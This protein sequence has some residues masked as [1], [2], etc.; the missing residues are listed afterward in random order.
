MFRLTRKVQHVRAEGRDRVFPEPTSMLARYLRVM[1]ELA[2]DPDFRRQ[3][4][5]TLPAG[6]ELLDA[7]VPMIGRAA[8]SRSAGELS[9]RR[10][11]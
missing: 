6:D 1:L 5:A 7:H 2:A 9:V 10:R 4:A 3:I 8:R 11:T